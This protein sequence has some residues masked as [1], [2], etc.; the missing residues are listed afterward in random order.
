MR[1]DR[2]AVLLDLWNVPSAESEI[3]AASEHLAQITTP[4]DP[5]CGAAESEE[6]LRILE[7]RARASRME[8]DYPRATHEW[9]IALEHRRAQPN[10]RPV[11]LAESLSLAAGIL[12]AR[13]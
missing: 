2:A 4:E 1:L 6:A 9:T 7:L 11:T 8:G 12:L 3:R 13:R 10:L 5:A